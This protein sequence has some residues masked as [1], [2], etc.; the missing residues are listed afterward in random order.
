MLMARR[1]GDVAGSR[2]ARRVL[3]IFRQPL[4][5]QRPGHRPL[6]RTAHVFPGNRRTG[7]KNGGAGHPRHYVDGLV[8][9]HQHRMGLNNALQ[10]NCVGGGDFFRQRLIRQLIE[11]LHHLHIALPRRRPVELGHG[12]VLFF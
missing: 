2:D 7:M 11:R 6:H 3:N 12:D 8:V 5:D 9:A 1:E 4:E 10:R